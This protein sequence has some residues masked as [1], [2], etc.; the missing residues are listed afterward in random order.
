MM[1]TKSRK[2]TRRQTI[3]ALLLTGCMLS[4]VGC[5]SI[6]G[7]I[8]WPLGW[9][10]AAGGGEQDGSCSGGSCGIPL[11]KASG[12]AADEVDPHRIFG[13]RPGAVK[14]AS[15]ER[16]REETREKNG[17]DSLFSDFR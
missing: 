4:F 8:P 13:D 14:Q 17:P 10:G 6:D 5:Q 15:A 1:Q 3:S 7:A 2:Q 12:D 9:R 16:S 11:A